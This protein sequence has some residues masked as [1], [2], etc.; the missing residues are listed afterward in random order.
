MLFSFALLERS[1]RST[2]STVALLGLLTLATLLSGCTLLPGMSARYFKPA[3]VEESPEEPAQT[4]YTLVKI[5]PKL[6]KDMASERVNYEKKNIGAGPFAHSDVPVTPYKLGPQDTLR[7]FVWGNPDLSP[8]TTT[9]SQAG[10]AST[11][12]GRTINEKGE[13]YFPFVGYIQAAGLTVSQFR[14]QLSSRLSKYIKDPQVEVDVAGFRSQKVFLAGEI[15]VPGIVP[16]T[17]QPMRITDAIGIAGGLTPEADLYNAVLTRNKVSTNINLDRIYYGGETS[18][19]IILIAGDVLSI[20]DR[21]VR[22]IFVLGE[23]GNAAGINQARSYV[24][25][26]GRMSLAEVISDAGGLNPF[27]S[28]PGKVFVMRADQNGEPLIYQLNGSDASSL[29]LAEQFTMRPRDVVFVAPT[30][31]TEIGRFIGQFFPLT[32]ATQA[33]SNT[34]F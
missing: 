8:V 25:R 2:F 3:I 12:A 6:V 30:D 17:D 5:T 18:A 13:L 21:Q 10:S 7:I 28:A 29:I 26:R 22:K 19:N 11:P 23:V 16:I 20:P 15:K 33:V 14:E 32:S 1:A 4:S 9:V 27:S 34:P 31:I 24:M